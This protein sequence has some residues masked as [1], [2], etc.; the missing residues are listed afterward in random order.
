MSHGSTIHLSR[1]AQCSSLIFYLFTA[2]LH[3]YKLHKYLKRQSNTSGAVLLL[4]IVLAHIVLAA[5]HNKVFLKYI[6]INLGA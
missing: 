3:M 6:S 2:L 4:H 1:N 5:F